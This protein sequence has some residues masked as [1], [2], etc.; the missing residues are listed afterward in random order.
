MSDQ[1][2]T[3]SILKDIEQNQL[4]VAYINTDGYNPRF[5]YSIG[6]FKQ[7]HHPEILLIGL[8]SD[9]TEAIINN[10]KNQIVEGTRFIEGVNY[11][12]FLIDLPVQ[13]IE[14]QPAHFPDY[15]GYASWYNDYQDFPVLQMIWPDKDGNFPWDEGFNEK[16]KFEQPLLDRNVDFKF[17]E[18]RNLG[19]YTT[20]EVLE[21]APVLYVYHDEEGDWQFHHRSEVG[22]ED[23]VLVSLES[24]VKRDSS[25]NQVYHL[26]YGDQA[27]RASMNNDWQV[28]KAE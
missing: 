6:L 2:I 11:P 3:E 24:L 9:S 17:L 13:F 14:V 20:K 25:L 21:G 1:H 7:F 28:L 27:M 22:N 12:D 5:G 10:A 18:E 26:N 16:F 8:D 15:M 19:V 4:C 23:G